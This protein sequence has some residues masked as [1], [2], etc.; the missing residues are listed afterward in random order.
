MFNYA[1]LDKCMN[2][3][4]H[5]KGNAYIGKNVTAQVHIGGDS[6]YET[7]TITGTCIDVYA[8]TGFY[9][10]VVYIIEEDDIGERFSSPAY[11]HRVWSTEA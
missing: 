11:Y 10:A 8:D 1:A 4:A 7:R 2:E 5:M 6:G 9:D 3:S